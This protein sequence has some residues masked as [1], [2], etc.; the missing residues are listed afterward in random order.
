M[1]QRGDRVMK[2]VCFECNKEIG[3][4]APFSD[5][6]ATHALCEPCL[7]K[8]L[9]RLAEKQ[10]RQKNEFGRYCPDVTL[11]PEG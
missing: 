8:M 4:K 11:T 6:Q 3:E 2:V 9:D 5:S 1:G 10:R 7:R